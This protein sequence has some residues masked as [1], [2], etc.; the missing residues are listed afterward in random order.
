MCLLSFSILRIYAQEHRFWHFLSPQMYLKMYN[1]ELI[2]ITDFSL[3]PYDKYQGKQ[4]EIVKY[5]ITSGS[6]KYA[7]RVR[8]KERRS[9]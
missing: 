2:S 4:I 1:L 8:K 3:S 6:E 5:I 9:D 7:D